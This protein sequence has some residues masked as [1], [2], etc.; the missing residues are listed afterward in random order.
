[1]LEIITGYGN[2]LKYKDKLIQ[3]FKKKSLN[4]EYYRITNKEQNDKSKLI[5]QVYFNPSKRNVSNLKNCIL[6]YEKRL[7]EGK[8]EY[9]FGLNSENNLKI[10]SKY[11]INFKENFSLKINYDNISESQ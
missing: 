8:Y 10:P 3:N 7:S 9:S 11:N 5:A 6:W 4:R 1:M 2:C